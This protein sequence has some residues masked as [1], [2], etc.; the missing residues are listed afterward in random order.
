MKLD[1]RLACLAVTL[2]VAGGCQGNKSSSDSARGKDGDKRPAP[3]YFRVDRATASR[4]QGVVRFQ[5]NPP[6]RKRLT[7]DSEADCQKLHRGPVYEE[8]VRLGKD[9][10]LANAFVYIQKGLEGKTFEPPAE[11]V[12]LEQKGC[13]FIP[14]VVGIRTGQ[15]LRVKNSDPVSHNVHPMPKNNR[16]WNQ[17]QPPLGPDLNRRFA[18]PEVMIPVKCNIH[19]WMK[20]YIG[21]L[22]HP[23][24]AITAEDG[25]FSLDNVPPG[26]YVVAAWHEATGEKQV[27]I[28]LG[29]SETKTVD[30]V[31][32][33]AN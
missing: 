23:Y 11:A 33:S 9:R 25:A 14:R 12:V 19:A 31:L 20:S 22:D 1:F 7:M 26:D 6:A 32:T 2:V 10:R 5:G 16:D 27:A 8:T 18:F 28:T 21:V 13:Q 29:A 24:F 15:T 17:Q 30:F 4:L 3:Q